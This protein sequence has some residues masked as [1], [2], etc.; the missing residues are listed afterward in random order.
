MALKM[1]A[2]LSLMLLVTA[3][4]V[5][6]A[7]AQSSTNNSTSTAPT[8]G[9][10]TDGHPVFGDP[11]THIESYSYDGE[12]LTVTFDSDSTQLVTL[13]AP[14]EESGKGTRSGTLE[15]TTLHRGTTTVSVY[16]P[17]GTVWISTTAS[18]QNGKFTEL[19]ADGSDSIVPP[20]PY[21]ATDARDVGIG[22]AAGVAVA[23]LWVAVRAKLGSA[24]RAERVA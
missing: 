7:L 19:D 20:G 23:H 1:T 21:D 3:A 24:D 2:M 15:R 18:T 6:T 10:A 16:S 22:A 8:A 17:T 11:G 12:T 14:P 4:T 13:T 5:P 9:N